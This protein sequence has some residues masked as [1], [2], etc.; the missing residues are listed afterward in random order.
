M[1]QHGPAVVSRV[2]KVA[3]KVSAS[4]ATTT[5][6][7]YSGLI[8]DHTH[9]HTHTDSGVNL[10]AFNGEGSADGSGAP[11]VRQGMSHCA[12]CDGYSRRQPFDPFSPCLTLTS[13]PHP[14]I[15]AISLASFAA[16][17]EQSVGLSAGSELG[18]SGALPNFAPGAASWSATQGTHM[19]RRV[20]VVHAPSPLTYHPAPSPRGTAGNDPSSNYS[21]DMSDDTTSSDSV[22]LHS[23]S[24]VGT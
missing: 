12:H 4:V 8:V 15:L 11:Q 20:V 6:Y 19:Q 3:T 9:T 5:R 18:F 16:A 1:G 2:A 17:N 21:D 13:P 10:T 24:G 14:F 7:S 23:E 22:S